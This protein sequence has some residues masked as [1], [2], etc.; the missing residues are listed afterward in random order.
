MEDERNIAAEMRALIDQ[1]TE[2]EAPYTPVIIAERIVGKLREQDPDLLQAW[3]DAHAVQ[4]VRTAVNQRDASRRAYA[5][6]ATGRALFRDAAHAAE[7]GDK[8]P[9]SRFMNTVYTIEDGTR[10]RLREMQARDL[11]FVADGYDRR[12]TDNRMQAA[13]FKALAQRVGVGKV[14][15]VFDEGRLTE[16]WLSLK[17]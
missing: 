16:L 3:L 9:L 13:F 15:D 6:M 10:V 2:D 5:R 8:G 14:S 11:S 12:A 17:G 4:M 7:A 1:E